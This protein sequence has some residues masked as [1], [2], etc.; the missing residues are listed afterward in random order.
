VIYLFSC[1]VCIPTL[2][3]AEDR[4]ICC[5]SPASSVGDGV[6]VAGEVS[7]W[8][9]CLFLDRLQIAAGGGT[10]DGQTV[11]ESIDLGDPIAVRAH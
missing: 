1:T 4:D 11:R 6:G 5:L 8:E 2:L 3:D 9:L 10:L 7:E